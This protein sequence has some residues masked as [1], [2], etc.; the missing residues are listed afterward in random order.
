MNDSTVSPADFGRVKQQQ[1]YILMYQMTP[2]T[3]EKHFKSAKE[4]ATPSRNQS[5]RSLIL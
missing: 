1:A 3:L 2:S 4:S 5:S